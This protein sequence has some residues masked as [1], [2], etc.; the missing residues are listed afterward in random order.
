MVNGA[1]RSPFDLATTTAEVA[2]SGDSNFR[3]GGGR[4][5]SF[6]VTLDGT[7]ATV[8]RPDA[9]VSWGQINAP[10]V[11]A[12]TEFSVE[13]GGFKAE[14]G[15]ASG[16]TVSFVSKSGTNEFHGDAYEFL[17]NQDLDARGFFAAQKA[18]YK[19]NDFGVTA[20]G[21]VYL[22]KIYKGRN[23]TFFFFSYEGFRNRVGA[24]ATPYTVPPP[25]FFTGDLHNW[26]NATGKMIPIYDP[27]ERM[28]RMASGEGAYARL[29]P[30]FQHEVSLALMDRG[31]G[32]PQIVSVDEE[33]SVIYIKTVVG[34]NDANI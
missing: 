30:K 29:G 17:R 23:R 15:H 31:F 8:A 16:G 11:E 4:I 3:V 33:D 10:S 22:P 1:V 12:L 28:G 20:G 14:I 7:A 34:V 9:Q 25:E 24:T 2:G 18:V 13:S 32:R 19:Q 21:P 6:G 26:V 27:I 5:G